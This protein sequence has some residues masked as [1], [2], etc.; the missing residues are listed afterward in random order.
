[1]KREPTEWEKIFANHVSDEGFVSRI[2]KEI[3]NLI[4][5]RQ[6]TQLKIRQRI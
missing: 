1:M 5:K 2:Y 6:L 3:Y 4:I